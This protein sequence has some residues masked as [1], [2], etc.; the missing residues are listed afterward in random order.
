MFPTKAQVSSRSRYFR[1]YCLTYLGEFKNGLERD[2]TH[3]RQPS[4]KSFAY[5]LIPYADGRAYRIQ[6]LL[7]RMGLS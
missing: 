5:L 7:G 3:P 6:N 2:T 1:V 4:S